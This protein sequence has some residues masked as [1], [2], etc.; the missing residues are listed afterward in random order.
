MTR[1]GNSLVS[2]SESCKDVV[3]ATSVTIAIV[4]AA[5]LLML[6]FMTRP[7]IGAHC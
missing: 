3:P 2:C 7:V 1:V 6:M 4:N 5:K